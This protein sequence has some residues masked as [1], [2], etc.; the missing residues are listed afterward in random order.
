MLLN[1]NHHYPLSPRKRFEPLHYGGSPDDVSKLLTLKMHKSLSNEFVELVRS[2]LQFHPEDRPELLN[3]RTSIID[4]I[5]NLEMTPASWP[6][7][8]RPD[9]QNWRDKDYPY[10]LVY[11]EEMDTIGA[12]RKDISIAPPVGEGS[13]TEKKDKGKKPS[14]S[15]KRLQNAK[16]DDGDDD[17]D[18]NNG[19]TKPKN[20]TIQPSPGGHAGLQ[21]LAGLSIGQQG[22]RPAAAGTQEPTRRSERLGRKQTTTP[23]RRS[24]K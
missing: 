22:D 15:S 14:R 2:C 16:G 1:P 12:R 11:G 5:E 3:L 21:A 23:R 8:Q 20:K 9:S 24:G 13:A 4:A 10:K 17:N 18:D 6:M 7:L 19:N